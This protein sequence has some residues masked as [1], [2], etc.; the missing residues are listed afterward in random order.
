[1]VKNTVQLSRLSMI[2]AFRTLL[3]ASILRLFRREKVLQ[4]MEVSQLNFDKV[5]PQVLADIA[6]A[7]CIA[8]D[9]ELTGLTTESGLRPHTFDSIDSRY[10]CLRNAAKFGVI[11]YGVCPFIADPD[12]GA[13]IAKPYTFLTLPRVSPIGSDNGKSG[14][15]GDA[16]LA[17]STS[18][19]E[20]L[21]RNSLDFNAVA[22]RGLTFLSREGEAALRH[23]RRSEAVA[24]LARS[25]VDAE[26]ESQAA[27]DGREVSKAR[28]ICQSGDAA[29]PEPAPAASDIVLSRSADIDWFQD[30]KR[31]VESWLQVLCSDGP[32]VPGGDF[33]YMLLPKGNG[34]R[35]RVIHT[36]VQSEHAATLVVTSRPEDQEGAD[37]FNKV[38][39]LTFVGAGTP[40]RS[41]WLR[42]EMQRAV[43][44][45]DAAVDEG[46]GRSVAYLLPC[47]Q[48]Q[49]HW[50]G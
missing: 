47:R 28:V 31:L 41:A 44:L 22:S 9:T 48:S 27:P 33:P 42:S 2:R 14:W 25:I 12:T 30:I 16:I 20:F 50:L 3:E 11:Q 6:S 17:L 36:W 40:G 46:A 43:D 5:L 15:G 49:R 38:Q 4:P 34:F 23:Q 32:G 1:L 7:S 8:I 18:A 39:R 24:K 21:S 13:F 26:E 37:D 10:A 35:R 19:V 29:V 45:V